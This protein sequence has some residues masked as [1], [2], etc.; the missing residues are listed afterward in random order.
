M[1]QRNTSVPSPRD[2]CA[3]AGPRRRS[4]N[5]SYAPLY[6]TNAVGLSAYLYFG[7]F[8]WAP[9]G[10]EG[11]FGGPGDPIVWVL[12]VFPWLVLFSLVNVAAFRTILVRLLYLH[13]WRP[14][15]GLAIIIAA[16]ILAFD[17]DGSR[18]YDGSLL[19]SDGA[20]APT[21]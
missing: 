11:L 19:R 5:A 1:T 21:H 16:W 7:S 2:R 10:E 9:R 3:F 20:S 8:L 14:A 12:T 15:L 18:Q 17:Y 13:R 6:V 4:A